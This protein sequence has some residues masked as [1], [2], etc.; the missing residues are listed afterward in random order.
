M[1]IT[2]LEKLTAAARFD[3]IHR[4]KVLLEEANRKFN[5]IKRIKQ[6]KFQEA[7]QYVLET[8]YNHSL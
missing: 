7:E 6:F 1:N 3:R 2:T 5:S 8:I 4:E